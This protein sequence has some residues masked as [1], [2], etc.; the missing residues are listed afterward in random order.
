MNERSKVE[1][2]LKGAEA[3]SAGEGDV[4]DVGRRG[5]RHRLVDDQGAVLQIGTARLFHLPELLQRLHH[6]H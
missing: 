5:G 6:V 2:Y 4:T 3:G 1:G